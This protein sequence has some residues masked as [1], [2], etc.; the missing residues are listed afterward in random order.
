MGVDPF[1]QGERPSTQARILTGFAARVRSGKFGRGGVVKADTVSTALS[2]IGKEIDMVRGVNPVKRQGS[3]K[4]IPRL[5]QTLDGWR[6]EDPPVQK[7][8]PVEVDVPEYLVKLGLEIGASHMEKALGNLVLIAFYFLLRVGE[9]TS[10][11]TRNKSKQTV[12]FHGRNVTFFK[13]DK[14]GALKQMSRNAPAHMIMSA[15]SAT[16]KLENQKNGWHGVCINHEHNGDEIF[17]PVRALGRRVL[18]L[19]E[20]GDA[21]WQNLPLSTVFIKG[22]AVQMTCSNST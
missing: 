20:F 14:S 12:Q 4:Y 17:S 13:R 19:R 15:D 5:S 2:A 10:K 16:L 8:L 3:D 22:E 18:H 11:G 9:Y 6:K 7:K 1:L 21:D